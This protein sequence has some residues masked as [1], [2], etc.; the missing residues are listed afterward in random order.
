MALKYVPEASEVVGMFVLCKLYKSQESVNCVC[1]HV[2]TT[3]RRQLVIWKHEQTAATVTLP[4]K[5]PFECLS[6]SKCVC[7]CV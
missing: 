6:Y 2:A 5:K 3:K 4:S 7:M 1:V